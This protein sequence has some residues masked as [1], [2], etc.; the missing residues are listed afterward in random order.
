MI[1]YSQPYLGQEVHQK[2]HRGKTKK[3]PQKINKY[4]D[5]FP[6]RYNCSSANLNE[7]KKIDKHTIEKIHN[8]IG[9]K[10][11]KDIYRK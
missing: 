8:K 10:D 5:V 11:E 4:I 6:K 7:Y 3:K 2:G 9:G 1:I